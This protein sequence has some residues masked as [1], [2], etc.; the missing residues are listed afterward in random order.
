MLK[1]LILKIMNLY[2]VLLIKFSFNSIWKSN[3]LVFNRSKMIL[4]GLL[5]LKRNFWRICLRILILKIMFKINV[6]FRK[7]KNLKFVLKILIWVKFRMKIQ[8]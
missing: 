1:I 4:I 2:L 3:V 8:I 6:F 5:F 7:K